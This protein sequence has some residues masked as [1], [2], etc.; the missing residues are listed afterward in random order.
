MIVDKA[1]LSSLLQFVQQYPNLLCV[2]EFILD[3]GYCVKLCNSPVVE[4]CSIVDGLMD[5]VLLLLLLLLLYC[6]V[7]QCW[8]L[9][10]FLSYSCLCVCVHVGIYYFLFQRSDGLFKAQQ[11]VIL[12]FAHLLS[13]SLS[14][15]LS[16]SLS[17]CPV[18]VTQAHTLSLTLWC[19]G[20]LVML[21]F[22]LIIVRNSFLVEARQTCLVLV[23]Q[24]KC[25]FFL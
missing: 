1:L 17:P 13:L 8:L 12:Q 3:H 21:S 7:W 5:S 2:H 20:M 6:L 10:D 16:L 4:C 11:E 19:P 18:H 14:F 24:L 15:P 25:D 22:V 9:F 23:G